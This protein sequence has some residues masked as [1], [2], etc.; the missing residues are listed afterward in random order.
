MTPYFE[1]L[2][3]RSLWAGFLRTPYSFATYRGDEKKLVTVY[4][5]PGTNLQMVKS[6]DL[7][8]SPLNDPLPPCEVSTLAE[9]DVVAGAAV[10]EG[11]RVVAYEGGA[12]SPGIHPQHKDRWEH[13]LYD[14]RFAVM[15]EMWLWSAFVRSYQHALPE[16]Q[17]SLGGSM[18]GMVATL[19]N[20]QSKVRDEC[21]R[22]W[23]YWDM[24]T[25][26]MVFAHWA[27]RDFAP[28]IAFNRWA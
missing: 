9:G 13:L 22:H 11:F 2:G 26:H 17:Y 23:Q 28:E 3:R 24:W 7:N 16:L 25:I 15:S 21:R 12:V 10:P 19:Q 8:V 6:W 14:S 18:F 27:N 1:Y 5:Y 4:E 20:Q